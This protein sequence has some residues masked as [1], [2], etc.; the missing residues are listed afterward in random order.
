MEFDQAIPPLQQYTAFCFWVDV[1]HICLALSDFN[2]F[3]TIF[4][5][6]TET[7][8]SNQEIVDLSLLHKI[9]DCAELANSDN[10][11]KNLLRLTSQM[12]SEKKG[13]IPAYCH[14]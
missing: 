8:I 10:N 9:Q 1:M 4:S 3:Y 13:V 6:L 14:Q 12:I 5:T 2:S 11:Y 7:T